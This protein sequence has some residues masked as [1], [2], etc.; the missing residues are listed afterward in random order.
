MVTKNRTKAQ[1]KSEAKKAV[2]CRYQSLALS[3]KMS[4]SVFN[5]ES[6]KRILIVCEGEKS[7][8]NYLEWLR[9]NWRVNAD[10]EIIGKCGDPQCVVERA[11]QEKTSRKRDNTPDLTYAIFDRDSFDV[12]RINKAYSLAKKN[13]IDI[14][15]SNESFE[16]WYLLH[17]IYFETSFD[18][19]MLCLKL[20]EHMGRTYCKTDEAIFEEIKDSILF[21]VKNAIKLERINGS[22]QDNPYTSIHYLVRTFASYSAPAP[23]IKEITDK[24]LTCFST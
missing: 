8:P 19:N 4:Q 17:F 20:T 13:N 16:I 15:F 10:V 5:S 14:A 11:I 18:R 2:R 9:E 22:T 12:E 1:L 21:A 23:G 3:M 6:R 7:E 24:I